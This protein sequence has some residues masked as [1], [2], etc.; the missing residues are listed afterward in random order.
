MC[1][2]FQGKLAQVL[3]TYELSRR[4]KPA[5]R[6]TCNACNPGLVRTNIQR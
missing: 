3:F 2:H 4:L 5:S 6:L 1:A